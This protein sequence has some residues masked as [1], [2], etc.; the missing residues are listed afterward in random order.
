MKACSTPH[1]RGEYRHHCVILDN[2]GRIVSEAKNSYSKTHPVMARASAKL[3]LVKEYAHAEML[4]I[5][6]AKGKGVKLV[7]VRVDSKGNLA[8]SM[9][10]VVCQ[11]LIKQAGIKSVEHST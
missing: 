2:K 6:R 8:Q 11:E 10:C 7:V 9:P 4:A 5:V 3:G 1:K